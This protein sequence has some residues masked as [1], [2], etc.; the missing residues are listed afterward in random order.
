MSQPNF[1]RSAAL[2]ARDAGI[3]QAAEHAEEVNPNWGDRAFEV[4]RMYAAAKRSS[5]A[6][7]TSEDVR[8]SILG[9]H[10]PQPPH[11]RA[12]GSVFQRAARSNLVIKAGVTH[13]LAE[14]C[15]CAFVTLWK[16]V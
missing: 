11:L 10:L 12:W 14:H 9:A 4:L 16:A 8:N 15:H 5:G 6:S 1:D 13:S 3:Q 7:F 2:A